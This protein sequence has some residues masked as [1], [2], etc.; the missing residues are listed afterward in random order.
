L[1]RGVRARHA[2]PVHHT[3]ARCPLSLLLLLALA[4]CASSRSPGDN[5]GGDPS[6]DSGAPC[7]SGEQRC[8]GNTV[9]V[10]N[11]RGEAVPGETCPS[12][13]APDLGCVAC[14]PGT[15]MCRD[16]EAL[17]C[18]P[19]GSGYV[20]EPCDPVQGMSCD[21]ETGRCTGAC[22][23]GALG[24][25]YIGC[26]YYP[27]VTGNRVSNDYHFA[28]AVANTSAVEATVTI[29][30]GALSAPVVV[31]VPPAR[32][33][34]QTL[35]WQP[36]LKLQNENRESENDNPAHGALVAGG[37]YHLR[38][39][40]PVTV[41]QFS[42]LEYALE[43]AGDGSS[44]SNDASLLLPTNVWR[45]RYLV[46]SWPHVNGV[47]PSLLA[48]TAMSDGTRVTIDPKAASLGGG[49]APALQVGTPQTVTLDAG[50][51]LQIASRTGDFTGSLVTSDRPIQVIGAHF[52]AKVPLAVIACDHL[53][54][55][56][57][58]V[59]ALGKRY[60]VHAPA[61]PSLPDGKVNVVRII[62]TAPNTTITYTPAQG[63]APTTIAAAG[64]F[65]E[66][67]GTRASFAI[68]A[69]HKVL[70]A[71]Y[72]QGQGA[73]GG[74]GDPS[75]VLAVPA[76]QFRTSYLFHAPINYEAN[77]VDVTAPTGAAI[78]LDG[79]ALTL[80]AI[81][82]SGFGL[83][84]VRLMAGPGGDGNHVITGDHP[85]GITVYGYGTYTSY[86]YPGGL[87]LRPVP[88]D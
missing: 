69:S 18:R 21:G 84:R 56:M 34:V 36:D 70:V 46:A 42:P 45:D 9:V 86:W 31:T 3:T 65:I 8:D 41:Y 75:M 54:E 85:F 38:S 66:I 2:T 82:A 81:G 49:G 76:E 7:R 5:D 43:G 47:N 20:S 50:G 88:V 55:S 40:V 73:G 19:D 35:P 63:R 39:T 29:E 60:V 59:E 62:A 37:A 27:T 52:C 79:T 6:R 25:S 28:V 16:G 68:E 61:L 13:C 30:D 74:A 14:A 78:T 64:D 71:Q 72:M 24:A 1:W 44:Y 23:A 17:A 32:V 22:S 51:V 53:E 48:V 58:S 77:F 33:V 11:D 26:E 15:G 80:T 67:E 10:C 83:A 12:A 57:F 4:A 87:D